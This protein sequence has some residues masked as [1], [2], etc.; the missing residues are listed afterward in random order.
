MKF[1]LLADDDNDDAQLFEEALTQIHL[2]VTFRHLEDGQDVLAF[3]EHQQ[4]LPDIIFL[5]INMMRMTGWDCLSAIKKN[6]RYRHID[7][8][9]YSTSESK[10]DKEKAKSLGAAGFLT[11]PTEF[12]CLV[13][14]LEKL[15]SGEVVSIW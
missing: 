7:V 3:L 15:A 14:T 4:E 12:R 6:E 9:M 8:I 2:P 5:D 1:F 10:R 13:D 11:K